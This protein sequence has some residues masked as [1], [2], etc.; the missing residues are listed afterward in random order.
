MDNK[1]FY[2]ETIFKLSVILLFLIGFSRLFYI[3]IINGPKYEEISR[4]NYVRI[5]RINPARGMILDEKLKPIVNNVPSINLYFKPYLIQNKKKLIEYLS[6]TLSIEKKNIEDLIYENRYRAYNE[7]LIA[8]NLQLNILAK[9]S[10]NMNYYPEL[11][12]K[13]EILRNYNIL[14]HFTGYV[15]KINEEEFKK[16]KNEDYTINSKIGKLG[17]EKYYEGLL[18]GKSG[19]EILQVDAHGRNLN[20]FKENYKKEPVNGF[21]LVLTINLDLQEYIQSIFPNDLAGAVVVINPKTGAILSYNSFP[22]YDQNWFASGISQAQ[23]DYLQEH[24]Q[25][26]LLD[27]VVLATYP[28]ASTFKVISAAF[29]LEKE[30]ITENTKLAYCNG[31]MQIGNRYYK[32]WNSLGHG[33]TNLHEAMAV[34]CDVYFYD[35]SARFDLNEFSKFT[36]DNLLLNKTGIDLPFERTGFFPN[37]DWYTKHYGRYFSSVG[38]KANLVIGQGEA[39][40]TPLAVC[41]YYAA[42]ANDGVWQSPHLLERVFNESSIYY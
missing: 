15:G 39:L 10:D 1:N 38:L 28:P 16:Y 5:K 35:L 18:T 13:A 41:N 23:W 33:R 20:L 21:N 30:Y 27:R 12:L 3:Q 22:E 25:K 6:T 14:N 9:I 8:E 19:F 4:K 31:G 34:S 40:T 36:Y 17:L 42:I 2:P 32:C 29:G 7:I 24:P 37:T 11:L 26:P